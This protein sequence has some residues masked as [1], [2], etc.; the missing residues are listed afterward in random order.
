VIQKT[1]EAVHETLVIDY[2]VEKC[3]S[4]MWVLRDVVE[5]V[6]HIDRRG[7]VGAQLDV[8]QQEDNSLQLTPQCLSLVPIQAHVYHPP[9]Y[10]ADRESFGLKLAP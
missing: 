6:R 4:L 1:C 8:V 9:S 5:E 7:P 10:R 3:L 2:L